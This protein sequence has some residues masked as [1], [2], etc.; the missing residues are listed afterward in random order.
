MQILLFPLELGT[1]GTAL[2]PYY[3]ITT[4]S[5]LTFNVRVPE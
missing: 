3:E 2:S 1:L 4:N 5:P